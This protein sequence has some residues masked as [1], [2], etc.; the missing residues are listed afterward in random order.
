LC[1][2]VISKEEAMRSRTNCSVRS[3]E[4]HAWSL[5]WLLQAKLLK[6]HGRLCT[7]AVVLDIVLRA[8]AR[9]ISIS[10]ACRTGNDQLQILLNDID[11]AIDEL[12]Y[13]GGS[14]N[15]AL[16]GA[17]GAAQDIE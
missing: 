16:L 5:E 4:V 11:E 13:A 7:A 8:A 1:Q 9:S 2:Q 10:A 17:D 6:D 15:R 14:L 3:A 12:L